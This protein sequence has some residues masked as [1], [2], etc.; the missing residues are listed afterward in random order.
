MQR[1]YVYFRTKPMEGAFRT[2]FTPE[3]TPK[4]MLEAR[5]VRRKI[6]DRLPRRIPGELVQAR[7]AVA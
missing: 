3:L 5:R 6:H 4:Q 7:E 1:G 2:G